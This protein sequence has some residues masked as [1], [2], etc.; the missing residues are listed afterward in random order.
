MQKLHHSPWVASDSTI[1]KVAHRSA[2]QGGGPHRSGSSIGLAAA[3][4]WSQSG[5]AGAGPGSRRGN[6]LQAT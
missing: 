1:A 3:A 4:I 5:V 6:K 2:G